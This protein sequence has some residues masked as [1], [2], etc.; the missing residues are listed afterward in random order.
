MKYLNQET[1]DLIKN[2]VTDIAEHL[3]EN[4]NKAEIQPYTF[5]NNVTTGNVV[6]DINVQYDAVVGYEILSVAEEAAELIN[7]TNPLN[8]VMYIA[9]VR[10]RDLYRNDPDG[11]EYVYETDRYGAEIVVGY[12]QVPEIK[13]ILK[14]LNSLINSMFFGYCDENHLAVVVERIK[15]AIEAYA[16]SPEHKGHVVEILKHQIAYTTSNP[17]GKLITGKPLNRVSV[18][19]QRPVQ[20]NNNLAIDRIFKITCGENNE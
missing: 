5:E 8:G 15:A 4:G 12:C 1:V 14:G 18:S 20:E 10:P 9:F 2:K 17:V 11:N 3:K 7:S 13:S 16:E 19:I 6:V